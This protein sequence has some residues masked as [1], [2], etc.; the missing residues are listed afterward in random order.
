MSA[1]WKDINTGDTMVWTNWA[2][3]FPNSGKDYDCVILD[4]T[5]GK[6]KN[7]FCSYDGYVD[8]VFRYGE[9]PHII[10]ETGEKFLC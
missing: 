7:I 2:D 3:N 1:D 9:Y 5:T 6:M 4:T 8:I 10:E